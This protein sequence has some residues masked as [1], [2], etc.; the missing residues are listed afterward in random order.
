MYQAVKS[1]NH[2]ALNMLM[3]H[4]CFPENEF[5]NRVSLVSRLPHAVNPYGFIL[6]APRAFFLV[7]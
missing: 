4:G 1:C 5:N 7:N 3:T 6:I 2:E